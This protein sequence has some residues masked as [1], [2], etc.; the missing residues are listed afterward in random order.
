M[1]QK[2]VAH[3]A[4]HKPLTGTEG[5][6]RLDNKHRPGWVAHDLAGVQASSNATIIASL[7]N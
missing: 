3:L 1:P 7:E 2:V 6:N 4:G 5:H